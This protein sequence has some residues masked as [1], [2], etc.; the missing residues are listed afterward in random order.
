[1][2]HKINEYGNIPTNSENIVGLVNDVTNKGLHGLGQ[3]GMFSS[4]RRP[5]QLSNPPCFLYAPVETKSSSP[6]GAAATKWSWTHTST[7]F[8]LFQYAVPCIVY[9]FVVW[10]TNA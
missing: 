1:M 10:P 2:A 9:Y 7:Y 3:S 6:D 5:D 8:F 4:P